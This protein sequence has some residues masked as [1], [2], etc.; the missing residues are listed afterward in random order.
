MSRTNPPLGG[1]GSGSELERALLDAG[2]SYRS[3]DHARTKTLAALGLSGSAAVAAGV[4]GALAG[5]SLAKVLT[6]A[7][8]RA[9]GTA[10]TKLL[11]GVS[12]VGLVAAVP[13][14][15][16]LLNRRQP[17]AVAPAVRPM[18]LAVAAA[19]A[20]P[21]APRL[22]PAPSG[23]AP[24]AAAGMPRL[25]HPAGVV[26][27]AGAARV[28]RPELHDAA[29]AEELAALDAARAALG[30]GDPAG[31]LSRLD[32]YA[33]AHP[34]GRLELEAEILRIDA[35]AKSGRADE[36]RKRA[37]VFLRRHPKSVLA[38]RA[39]GYLDD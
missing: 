18:E 5:S 29:L 32:G 22:D 17:P 2:R 21:P 19:V 9:T 25:E 13:A 23:A 11:A 3:S 33:R 7:L 39:R 6:R 10:W 27:H 38:A 31:A 20:D 24:S 37:E 16:Y 34:G 1:D 35:I 36:A 14:G 26:A 15:H 28:A 12:V 4:A 8:G 30:A